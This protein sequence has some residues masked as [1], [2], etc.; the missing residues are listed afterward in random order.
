MN[1]RA[2]VFIAMG[3]EAVAAVLFGVWIGKKFDDQ[4]KPQGLGAMLGA[5]VMLIGWMVHLFAMAK[6]FEED[7]NSKDEK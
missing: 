1:R 5:L 4:L 3:F 2:M 6:K 7:E